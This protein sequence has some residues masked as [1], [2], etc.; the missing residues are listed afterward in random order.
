MNRFCET[1][2]MTHRLIPAVQ[3]PGYPLPQEWRNKWRVIDEAFLAMVEAPTRQLGKSVGASM[4]EFVETKF[5]F[6][7]SSVFPFD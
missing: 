6:C 4:V 3:P 1:G 2:W 5:P 7:E